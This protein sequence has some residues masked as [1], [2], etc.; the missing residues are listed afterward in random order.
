MHHTRTYIATLLLLLPAITRAE[1]AVDFSSDTQVTGGLASSND[2]FIL[3]T[4]NPT[5]GAG[6]TGYTGQSIYGAFS[7][8]TGSASSWNIQTTTGGARIRWNDSSG[9][10]GDNSSAL[11]LFR[12]DKISFTI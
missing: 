8:N 2:A 11:Y 7:E 3:D 4:V 5:L 10:D 12:K 9:A 1:T 6:A